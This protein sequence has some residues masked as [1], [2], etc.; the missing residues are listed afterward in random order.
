[1]NFYKQKYKN[2]KFL[3][4]ISGESVGKNFEYVRYGS[5]FD[6]FYE[7]F[8]T[9]A[10]T[11]NLISTNMAINSISLP[12]LTEYFQMLVDIA[13][14]NKI[15]IDVAANMIYSPGCLSVTI[16]DDSFKKYCKQA[17]KYVK[18][19]QQYFLNSDEILDKLRF[20]NNAINTNV[21]PKQIEDVLSLFEYVKN[22][23]KLD[24]I[25][26]NKSLWDYVNAQM[27]Q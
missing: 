3:I 12:Y 25:D 5:K 23:R 8:N 15:K 2:L 1:M 14:Q 24:I 6:T 7:N 9:W 22:V 16:L 18:Q 13:Q 4:S 19:N 20:V 11:D 21:S 26:V 10:S 27:G 17:A